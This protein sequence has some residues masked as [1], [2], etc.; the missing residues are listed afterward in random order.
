MDLPVIDALRIG[1]L[2]LSPDG[3]DLVYV[4]G[5][6]LYRR[7]MGA[8]EATAIAGTEAGQYPFFSPDG[9]WIGFFADGFLKK[10]A[11]S[12]GP[13]VTICEAGFRFGAS[14]GVDDTIVFAYRGPGA[15]VLFRVPA[16]GGTPLPLIENTVDASER[17]PAMLPGGQGVLFTI[18]PSSLD[19][20]HVAVQSFATG[21]I[22]TLLNGTHARYVATGHLLFA[23]QRSLWAV[24]FDLDR[25]ELAGEPERVIEALRVNE[26]GMALYSVATNG[27]LAYMTGA[28]GTGSQLFWVDPD[29][30]REAISEPGDYANPE[31][32]PDGTQ[33]AVRSEDDLWLFDLVRGVRSRFTFEGS[34]VNAVWSPDG[35][36][37]AFGSSVGSQ[38][39]YELFEK[40]ANATS[41]PQ[42]ILED[43]GA[44]L[45]VQ[46][47]STDGRYVIYLDSTSDIGILPT[48]GGEPTTFME[49]KY[50]ISQAQLS[51]DGRWLAYTSNESVGFNVYVTSFPT[52]AAKWQV[53]SNGGYQ[54]RWSKDGGIL[55]YLRSDGMLV[56][57]SASASGD[58]LSFETPKPV[59]SLGNDLFV[60]TDV[61]S[62][63]DV[64]PEGERF[65]VNVNADISDAKLHVVL[66]WFE[67]L[68]RLVPTP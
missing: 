19:D 62:Q 26:G 37:L 17:W 50:F 16:S 29:G 15:Q 34:P 45:S 8:L 57:V 42:L 64:S 60:G 65:V 66:D 54:P 35:A 39:S 10:V 58:S 12:G 61:S 23:W 2:A 25:L 21:E 43:P 13:P 53:S 28:T 59:F 48:D 44:N 3:G 24:A 55:Y 32:S 56:S 49:T 30:R 14:W 31:L 52:A 67:E 27:S 20:A 38:G 46:D 41:V 7:P 51:P 11:L 18:I 22:K 40:P 68:N 5:N 63:Y 6:Q 9:K 33:L 4:D 36:R 1:G 47:W